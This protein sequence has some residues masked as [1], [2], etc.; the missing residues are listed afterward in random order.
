MMIIKDVTSSL[1]AMHI[2]NRHERTENDMEIDHL[3]ETEL[4]DEMDIIMSEGKRE[5]YEIYVEYLSEDSSEAMEIY[6]S[7][8]GDV[9]G[10]YENAI[11]VLVGNMHDMNCFL[12]N[13]TRDLISVHILYVD[14]KADRP[15]KLQRIAL[16]EEMLHNF[17]ILC[18][19]IW[20]RLLLCV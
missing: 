17:S 15:Y 11:G 20:I 1:N 13:L 16:Y 10:G 7:I 14:L 18:V 5:I 19:W 12:V 9:V 3:S 6:L 4:L 8:M 2:T